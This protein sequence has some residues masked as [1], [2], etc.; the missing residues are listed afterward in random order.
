MADTA[1]DLNFT[2]EQRLHLDVDGY[3]VVPGFLPQSEVI[4][5]REEIMETEQRFLRDG[6]RPRAPGYLSQTS[7]GYFR[8]DNL[9]HLAGCFHRYLSSPR[10]VGRVEEMVGHEP[11]LEQSDAHI[12]RQVHGH[13]DKFIFHRS[14]RLGLG[15]VEQNGLYHYPFVKALTN[16]TDLDV[17]DGGTAV[18][19]GSHKL[20][21]NLDPILIQAAARDPS[22]MAQVIAPAGS[23]LF[24][25]E[26]LI[27]SAGINRSGKDRLLVIGGF[28]PTIFQPYRHPDPAF[29]ETLDEREKALYSGS[30]GWEGLQKHR[31]LAP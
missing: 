25:Y 28:T 4:A 19:P 29:I 20:P 16:L 15:S 3:L 30:K 21:G 17:D 5:L 8:I 10:L 27:H 23:T 24:F 14:P 11:R 31:S 18:I 7:T 1:S 26:S 12:R 6:T 2:V 9:P 13:P 22:L